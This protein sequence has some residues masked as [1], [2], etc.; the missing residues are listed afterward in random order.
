M[1]IAIATA[2]AEMAPILN[3]SYSSVVV[4]FQVRSVRQKQAIPAN[5]E[6]TNAIIPAMPSPLICDD[7]LTPAVVMIRRNE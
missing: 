2:P 6:I 5:V 3:V 7:V 1:A 4:A